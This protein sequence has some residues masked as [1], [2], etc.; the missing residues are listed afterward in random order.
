MRRHRRKTVSEL[1][2][3]A[4]FGQAMRHADAAGRNWENL[5]AEA[6][7][8]QVQWMNAIFPPLDAPVG[9][10]FRKSNATSWPFASESRDPR[11]LENAPR[12]APL[13]PVL[14]PAALLPAPAPLFAAVPTPGEARKALVVSAD[15]PRRTNEFSEWF[16]FGKS[17]WGFAPGRTE[18]NPHLQPGQSAVTAEAGPGPETVPGPRLA[19][20][21][22]AQSNGSEAS[23]NGATGLLPRPKAE[24]RQDKK[25]S[26]EA[27][28]K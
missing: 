1:F 25:S 21:E 13:T 8:N 14:H 20:L 18:S 22:N 3:A 4:I 23:S 27:M 15:S 26:S 10:T 6:P 24:G 2:A 19:A 16:L 5:P 12:P 7:F 11:G 28:D 17:C 9:S